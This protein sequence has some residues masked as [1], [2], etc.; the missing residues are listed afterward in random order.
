[1]DMMM[2]D[3]I[4]FRFIDNHFYHKNTHESLGSINTN[5]VKEYE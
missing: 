1:M 2:K 5:S 4:Y 3:L